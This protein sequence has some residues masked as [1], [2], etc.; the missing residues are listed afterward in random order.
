MAILGTPVLQAGEVTN[1]PRKTGT[2]SGPGV[3]SGRLGNVCLGR[4]VGP[5]DVRRVAAADA[6]TVFA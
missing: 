6:K 1:D 2:F 3:L 5:D 4:G